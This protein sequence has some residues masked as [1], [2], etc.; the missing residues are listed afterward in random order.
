MKD[1]Q[2]KICPFQFC[3]TTAVVCSPQCALWHQATEAEYM[4]YQESGV[5]SIR[6]LA[7]AITKSYM[8]T[9]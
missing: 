2:Y 3:S 1:D 5:C 4:I 9:Q 8:R 7:D 6:L